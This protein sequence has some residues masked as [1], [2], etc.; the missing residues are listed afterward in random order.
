M[1]NYNLLVVILLAVF[2]TSCNDEKEDLFSINENA[3]KAQY[4]QKD[5]LSLEIL[6]P[7]SELVQVK[8][9]LNFHLH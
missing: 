1:K 4:F 8:E 7:T 2:V 6:N 9:Q 5:Q 3:L